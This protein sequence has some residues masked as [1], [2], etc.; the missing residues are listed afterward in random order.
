MIY[1]RRELLGH[2]EMREDLPKTSS[3]KREKVR[4]EG[5]KMS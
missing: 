3:I 1:E 5:M 2:H 4:Q